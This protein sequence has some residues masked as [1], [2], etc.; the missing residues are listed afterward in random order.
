M[1]KRC[2]AHSKMLLARNAAGTTS[3][4]SAVG[5]LTLRA[6]YQIVASPSPAITKTCPSPLYQGEMRVR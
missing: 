1:M 2:I 4:S 3:H 6:Q 5:W